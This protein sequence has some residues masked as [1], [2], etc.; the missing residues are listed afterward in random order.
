MRL[1]HSLYRIRLVGAVHIREPIKYWYAC[2]VLWIMLH[3][4]FALRSQDYKNSSLAWGS[5]GIPQTRVTLAYTINHFFPIAGRIFHLFLVPV[6]LSCRS[7]ITMMGVW[8]SDLFLEERDWSRECANLRLEEIRPVEVILPEKWRKNFALFL[9]MF[10][11]QE[12][13]L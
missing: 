1:R 3:F 2:G 12:R 10:H 11:D 6:C 5:K 13:P 7:E 4:S 9:L 8:G